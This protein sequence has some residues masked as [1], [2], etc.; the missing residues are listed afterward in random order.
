VKIINI[1]K[2]KKKEMATSLFTG[3]VTSQSPITDEEGSDL[4]INYINFPKGVANK[5]HK[6]SNDQI[7]IVTKG[8]GFVGTKEKVYKVKEGDIIWTPKGEAHYHGAS[9]SSAF[10]HIS[11]TRSKT[12]LTQLEK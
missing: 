1:K 9:K 7:L 4:S 10:T 11:I 8:V 5:L 12:K 2:I 3:K 6:H